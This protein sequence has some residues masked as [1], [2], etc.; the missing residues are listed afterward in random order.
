VNP[1]T[2]LVRAL[3]A[4]GSALALPAQTLFD[5]RP[6]A[7]ETVLDT[8]S[9]VVTPVNGAP[10][11]VTGGVFVFRNV[12]IPTGVRVT[13]VGSRPMIWL[14]QD[15]VVDGTLTV[16]GG[17]GERVDT[18]NSA[19]IPSR[20]GRGGAAGG[21]G[22]EGSPQ[23]GARSFAGMAGRGPGGT[24]GYGGTGGLIGLQGVAAR[25]SAGGGG[26]FATS[27][28]PYHGSLPGTGTSFV[29]RLGLGGYGG[30]GAS[31]SGTRNLPGG[32]PGGSPF[33]D[34][35]DENDFVGTAY[36]F[37]RRRVVPGEL[38]SLTGGTG[39]GGGGNL[40]HS[41][42]F[43][44][45]TFVNDAKGGG[46][47]GGGGCVLIFARNS[48]TV[49]GRILANGGHGGGGEQAGSCNEGGGGGG[50]S[51]GLMVLAAGNEVVLTVRG[52]TYANRDYDFVLSAD[53]GVCTTGSFGTPVI[54]GKYP[55]NGTPLPL[56]YGTSYD[57]APL[58][59]F[60]G[61]GVIQIVTRPGNNQD[62]T[63]TVLDDGIRLMGPGG[64]L[65]GA[66]KQRFLAW[67]GFKNA[68]GVR[69]DDFGNPT[70]I[71][72][73]EGDMRPSP[74]LMPLQ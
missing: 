25:G 55:A 14:V 43:L 34:G 5:Y 6:T 11:T 3:A 59:G 18:L 33:F 36:D 23:S 31:G 53:G 22:G 8:D 28:D 19:N 67:R 20:G 74:V 72:A 46:G 42:G 15:M 70:N 45:P 50:G 27:G 52:E 57:S 62:G 16:S 29:Q 73:S 17:D 40:A 21:R 24:P 61:M 35:D 1:A 44:S 66:L 65:G 30:L 51:G 37:F 7:S 56:N 69:V 10:F 47:G 68:A 9:T 4:C 32:G 71:G 26:A 58:G 39:G 49:S 48:I 2:T 64:V 13:G 12:T 60:G 63:N 38:L 41:P 54:S